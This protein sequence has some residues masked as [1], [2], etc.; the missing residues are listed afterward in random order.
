MYSR[1]VKRS[2]GGK[3]RMLKPAMPRAPGITQTRYSGARTI[4]QIH[5]SGL[6]SR[7]G[8]DTA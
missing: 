1:R 2:A 6:R 8:I 3:N 7:A 4:A 5:A